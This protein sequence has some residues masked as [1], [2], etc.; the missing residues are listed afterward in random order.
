[1]IE[2]LP[3][4]TRTAVMRPS[5]P[6]RDPTVLA[7]P[8]AEQFYLRRLSRSPVRDGEHRIDDSVLRCRRS[9]GAQG[10]RRAMTTVHRCVHYGVHP[11]L[12]V[13]F[14]DLKEMQWNKSRHSDTD[15][16]GVGL[17]RPPKSV[18]P[19]AWRS[20]QPNM[21]DCGKGDVVFSQQLHRSCF[22]THFTP[23]VEPNHGQRR[24][25]RRKTRPSRS[26]AK[27]GRGGSDL[28]LGTHGASRCRW[29]AP[30]S[31]RWVAR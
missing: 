22:T 5:W 21:A 7:P 28:T 20:L 29:V 11:H 14:R 26:Q 24:T 12:A 13:N 10:E 16:L 9:L 19:K 31:H 27:R 30:A 6:E 3:E 25:W 4:P 2:R 15:W 1:M 8:T 18:P 23:A 17:E